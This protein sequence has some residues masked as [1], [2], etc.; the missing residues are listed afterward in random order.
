MCSCQ[1]TLAE[2]K[3]LH[4]AL[5]EFLRC[6][7]L[8]TLS[9]LKDS[10]GVTVSKEK[11]ERPS[12]AYCDST[13]KLGVILQQLMAKR[14]KP[15]QQINESVA[16]AWFKLLPKQLAQH[17]EVSSLSGG[18]LKVLVDSPIYMYELNLCGP[19]LLSELQKRCPQARLKEIKFAIG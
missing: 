14:L 13:V 10:I 11:H 9:V 6:A 4:C 18:Q 3:A 8:V 12:R 19:E 1:S 7:G 5:A 15:S 2:I 17:C 16:Q